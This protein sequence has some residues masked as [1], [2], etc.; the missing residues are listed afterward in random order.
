MSSERIL[1]ANWKMNL[2]AEASGLLGRGFL[3]LSKTAKRTKIWIAPSFTAIPA[4]SKILSNSTIALGAQNVHWAESGAFTGE[5]SSS[6][7]AEF[8]CSFALIG[9]SERRHILGE[10]DTI[11]ATRAK[12][13]LKGGITPLFCIGETLEE[14]EKDLTTQ[15][16]R[17]QL[18]ALISEIP[19]ESAA[20]VI[21]AYE[22]VWAIG[23]GKVASLDN[24]R[25]AHGFIEEFYRSTSG[26]S[27]RAILY[28][29]SVSP[30]NFQDILTVPHVHGGLVGG[31][32]LSAEKFGALI[33]ISEKS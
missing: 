28:G 20:Q 32:S 22:P 13:A 1:A 9:H 33:G 30:D 21:V 18:E 15:V 2:T 5:I 27:P 12:G 14:R 4:L 26:E 10:S 23:T 19:R 29:G 8:G 31:A 16:L 17:I 24:I 3:D 7:L 6:M 11:V 25:D